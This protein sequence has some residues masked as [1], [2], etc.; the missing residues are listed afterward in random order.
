[1]FIGHFA[2]AFAAQPAAPIAVETVMLATWFDR[3]GGEAVAWPR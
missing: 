2:V 3:H 1:V